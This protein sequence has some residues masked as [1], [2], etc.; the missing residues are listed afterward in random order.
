MINPVQSTRSAYIKLSLFVFLFTF[1]WAA[2]FGLY[3]IWLGDKAGLNGVEIGTVF[4]VNGVFAVL[5][6]PVYGYIMDKIGMKKH[7]LYFVCLV[8]ALM[9]PFY[10]W[11]YLPLLEAHFVTG[12][13]VGALF[14]SLGWY[15]GVAAEES[16]T[17][18]FSR[19]YDM[20]FGRIRMWAALGWA[21]ASSFSGYLYN[22]SP[23]INFTISSVAALCMFCVLLTLKVDQFGKEENNV[24]SKEKIVI[25]DVFAL[26]RNRKFWTFAL[27][28][29]GVAWMMFIAEQQFSRYFVTFFSSKEEG[30]AMFGY[31][32]TVQSATE[33]FGMMLVPAVV[34]RIGAKQGMILTGLVISLRL[35]VSGLTT[36]PL[37][38]CLVKPLYCIEIALI[39]VSVF[40]YIA[41][42]FDKRVNATMYLLGYQAMVY[43]GSVVIAPPAGYGY[44]TIGFEHTYLIMGLIAL[45]F[46]GIS[47]MTLSACTQH[48]QPPVVPRREQ[49]AVH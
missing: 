29:A 8:S 5:I 18:R 26:F 32:S 12:M 19:L 34:N 45:L 46:T 21:T 16:Y 40:K 28:I 10:I 27:Y 7:L 42:H 36:D 24:L 23:E 38:I 48:R 30:N 39:L 15:A 33:F 49:K 2:S 35:I 13:I 22:I 44:Q 47:T 25:G 6:K 17:D 20:E 9:A 41:E 11:V 37:I 14:F 31:M 1:T 43:V 4:A 3:A